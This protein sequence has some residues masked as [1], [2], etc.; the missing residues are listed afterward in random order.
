MLFECLFTFCPRAQY[1]Y[2]KEQDHNTMYYKCK[3]I[4]IPIVVIEVNNLIKL[5]RNLFPLFATTRL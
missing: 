1:L 5:I 3:K 4:I 2:S